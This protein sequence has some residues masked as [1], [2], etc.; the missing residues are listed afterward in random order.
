MWVWREPVSGG[1]RYHMCR[2]TVNT[3]TFFDAGRRFVSTS[4]DKRLIVWEYGTPVPVKEI[5]DPTLHAVSAACAHPGGGFLVGQSMDNT[6]VTY[7]MGDRIG[8]ALKKT[9][10]GHISAGYACQPG[11]SPDGNYVMSGDTDGRL[12]IWDW[13]SCKVHRKLQCHDKVL[14]QALW[15]PIEPS[16]VA[17]CSWDGTIKF[18]D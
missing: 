8:R 17:T 14:I 6:L 13:K 11:V 15:H 10:S 5:Q 18:W 12:W 4:D 16:T 2:T 9:F 7:A 3:V 1:L